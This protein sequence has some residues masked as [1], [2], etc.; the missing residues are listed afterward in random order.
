MSTRS[1]PVTD[2]LHDYL[3]AHGSPPDEVASDLY[4]E[5][6]R[7]L[8]ADAE[9]QVAPEQAALL[10]LLTRLVGARNAVEVGTFTGTSALAIARGL[11]PDGRLICCDVSEEY[12]SIARRFWRRAGVEDRIDLRIAPAV[13]TLRA[14]PTEPHLDLAFIDADKTGYPAYWAEL[15][16]RM[17]P[18]GLIGV[19]N[20][21]RN[22]R[23]LAPVSEADR[24]VADF[25]AAVAADD[26]V[27][28]VMLPLADG[29]TL[30]R[31]R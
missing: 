7:I 26:R 5:T 29:M 10:T 28:V 23:V 8:P 17:R 13:Q 31:R 25:N 1:V 11:P 4:A 27:E 20:V 24:V 15:V 19:D 16:P 30:A 21:F 6:R 22:G 2:E 3:V 14:L 9:M 12:T 18:G